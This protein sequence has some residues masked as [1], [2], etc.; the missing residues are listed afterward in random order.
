MQIAGRVA[1]QNK[2]KKK[3]PIENMNKRVS[4]NLRMS[5]GRVI[6]GERGEGKAT[7]HKQ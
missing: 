4:S 3:I 1:A 5:A 7:Q 2:I 6:R